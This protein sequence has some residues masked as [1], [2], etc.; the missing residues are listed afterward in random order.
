VQVPVRARIAPGK[1]GVQ[2][3]ANCPLRAQVKASVLEKASEQ[4]PL[5][6]LVP[7]PA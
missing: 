6:V 1:T 5:R 3:L 7:R 2:L 4:E